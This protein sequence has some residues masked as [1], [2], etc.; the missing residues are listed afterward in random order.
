MTM[1]SLRVEK[2]GKRGE[3]GR[4]DG[5]VED[6]GVTRKET[7]GRQETDKDDSRGKREETK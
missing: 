2:N 7:W 5:K 4:A 3:E 6:R 1:D